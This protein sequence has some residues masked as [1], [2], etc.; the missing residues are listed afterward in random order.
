MKALYLICIWMVICWKLGAADVIVTNAEVYTVDDEN[1][2]AEAL[3]IDHG[4]IVYVGNQRKA[5]AFKQDSTEL[6]D[7]RGG[8]VLPGFIESHAHMTLAG[9]FAHAVPLSGLSSERHILWRI[10]QYITAH[11]EVD[12]VLGFGWNP[13][14]FPDGPRK[15][16]LDIVAADIPVVLIAADAKSA[17]FNSKAIQLLG[18]DEQSVDPL[19]GKHFYHKGVDGMLSGW[20]VGAGAYWPQIESLGLLDVEALKDAIE[21][22]VPKYLE[23]GVTSLYDPG[24]PA[25]THQL[26]QACSEMEDDYRLPM[27]IAY[28]RVVLNEVDG[29]SALQEFPDLVKNR[30][31]MHWPAALHIT[32]D[33]SIESKSARLIRPYNDSKNHY[34]ETLI[35]QRQLEEFI[36]EADALGIPTHI[37]AV[38]DCA[39][40]QA[41][42]AIEKIREF[43]GENPTRHTLCH[44]QLVDRADLDRFS[45]LGVIAQ[46]SPQWMEDD[47]GSMYRLW[48]K[49]LGIARADRQFP[50]RALLKHSTMMSLGSA[51]PVSGLDLLESSPLHGIQKG[52]TR[53]SCGVDGVKP[54]P[55]SNQSLGIRTLI[56]AATLNGAYQLG[57]EG[58]MG[59]LKVGKVGDFI[60]LDKNILEVPTHEIHL[61]KVQYT[62]VNGI[63]VYAA[64]S[65]NKVGFVE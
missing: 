3:V 22:I 58:S 4:K 28:G 60:I 9:V 29:A 27:R 12:S 48:I 50:F 24:I 6:I 46:I 32:N 8:S 19:E 41:L 55:P 34:G 33:G 65:Q 44:L 23:L 26:Q 51:Y 5:M 25:H 2:H 61:L 21:E 31:E 13:K 7:A 54:L 62:Y 45:K 49:R 43:R 59:S 64:S 53:M 20:F 56:R 10:E 14:L 39:T 57:A 47:D 36:K 30:S 38:G 52:I 11:P 63:Q 17:W 15:E 18:I 37:E 1:P 35:A 42:N 16:R 40:H